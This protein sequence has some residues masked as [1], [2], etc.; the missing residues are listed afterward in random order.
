MIALNSLGSL[1]ANKNRFEEARR[2]FDEALTI[3]RELARENPLGDSQFVAMTLGN[4]GNI[5]RILWRLAEARQRLKESMKT[6]RE[7]AEHNSER[8]R[9]TICGHGTEQHGNLGF[10]SEPVEGGARPL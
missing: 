5:N 8:F 4:L 9:C 6:Y 2:H 7:F 10:L 1:D 3:S